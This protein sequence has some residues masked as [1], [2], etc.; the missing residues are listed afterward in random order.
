MNRL[1]EIRQA[2][3]QGTYYV[4]AEEV[5]DALLAWLFWVL[6]TPRR[7]VLNGAPDRGVNPEPTAL[8]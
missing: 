2:V 4:P 7:R 3:E 6:P 5:A 1:D 8:P